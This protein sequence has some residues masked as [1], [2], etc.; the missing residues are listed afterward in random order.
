MAVLNYTPQDGVLPVDQELTLDEILQLLNV[1]VSPDGESAV[2]YADANQ[3]IAYTGTPE[4]TDFMP[5]RGLPTPPSIADE[6]AQSFR[7]H[8]SGS[9]KPVTDVGEHG[10]R[11]GGYGV[12][13]GVEARLPADFLAKNALLGASL[14]G[15]HYR[16]DV[17]LPQEMQDMGAPAE[18]N[19]GDTFI[20]NV[21][22]NYQD[23][24]ISA[25]ANYNP[26]SD[27]I[28]ANFKNGGFSANARY[29]PTTRDKMLYAKYILNF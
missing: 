4:E 5:Q 1:P 7:V 8:G 12:S 22:L 23:G 6:I 13:G 27:D 20:D 26:Q 11:Q 2:D 17:Y 21:G 15:S 29:N 10:V 28:S 24:D 19:Y 16:G 18:I 9:G 14:G 3:E 25:G